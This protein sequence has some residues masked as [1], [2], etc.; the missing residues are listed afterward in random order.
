MVD[1]VRG[2]FDRARPGSGRGKARIEAVSLEN[3]KCCCLSSGSKGKERLWGKLMPH[4]V[5]P[6]CAAVLVR[7][8]REARREPR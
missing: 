6:A 5:H 2:A 7:L 3:Y 4:K 1:G 8:S